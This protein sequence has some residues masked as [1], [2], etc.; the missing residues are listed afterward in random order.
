MIKRVLLPVVGLLVLA[1]VALLVWALCLR[2]DD[3]PSET[4]VQARRDACHTF[5]LGTIDGAAATA[6][7]SVVEAARDGMPSGSAAASLE[8][9]VG[10]GLAEGHRAALA[11]AMTSG[12]T[13]G[14]YQVFADLTAGFR[15]L[16]QYFEEGDSFAL[17]RQWAPF[18]EK[19]WTAYGKRCD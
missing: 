11:A 12:L 3:E 17:T 13:D 5:D 19:A 18:A 16:V 2:E 1:L 14:D 10:T 4:Q 15:A 9:R 8:R 6:L 7:T